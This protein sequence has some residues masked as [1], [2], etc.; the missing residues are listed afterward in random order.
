M[1]ERDGGFLGLIADRQSVSFSELF[2][3]IN[4][5]IDNALNQ[6]VHLLRFVRLSS[7]K[8]N[9]W[10]VTG[11][12]EAMGPYRPQSSLASGPSGC[13]LSPRICYKKCDLVQHPLARLGLQGI[14][15]AGQRFRNGQGKA[16]GGRGGR[17]FDRQVGRLGC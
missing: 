2:K 10:P 15:W 5:S 6:V 4:R 11:R 3:R 8:A 17:L 13:E 12:A 14:R 7:P 1:S 16:L 9:I